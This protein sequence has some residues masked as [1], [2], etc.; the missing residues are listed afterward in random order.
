MD[1]EYAL[2][3][4]DQDNSDTTFIYL[5]SYLPDKDSF[6]IFPF[7]DAI[8]LFFNLFNKYLLKIIMCKTLDLML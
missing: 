7:T 6:V 8:L 3:L 2:M 5:K 4:I 1:A